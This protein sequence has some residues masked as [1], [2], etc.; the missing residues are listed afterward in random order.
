LIDP[1]SDIERTTLKLDPFLFEVV[2]KCHGVV[3]HERH[4]P[5]VEHYRLPRCLG[6]EQLLEL[7]DSRAAR[8]TTFP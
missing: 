7:L 6:D 8:P 2:E 3:V 4:V 5:Q 1:I